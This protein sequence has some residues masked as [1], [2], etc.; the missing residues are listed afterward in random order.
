MLQDVIA[1][2][3]SRFAALACLAAI[4]A[5]YTLAAALVSWLTSLAPTARP[6]SETFPDLW[7]AAMIWAALTGG[8]AVA[9]D[10]WPASRVG[11]RRAVLLYG[12]ILLGASWVVNAHFMLPHWIAGTVSLAELPRRIHTSSLAHLPFNTVAAAALVAT[13]HWIGALQRTPGASA[14]RVRPAAA[15]SELVVIAGR[16][17]FTV[18]VAAIE[19]I[20]SADD[21]TVL[22]CG[23]AS[24]ICNERLYRLEAKLANSG[25]LRVHRSALVNVT[26]I[27]ALA[28]GNSGEL[29]VEL[30]S[31][32]R[33]RAS[34]RR[35]R[36][37]RQAI[38]VRD[39]HA[40]E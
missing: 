16:R 22:H 39:K 9:V 20:E 24:H 33:V 15:Q 38:L 7:W 10:T 25:F 5:G 23:T 26:H 34:R 18:P 32:S 19:W 29:C 30:A 31:G 4:A 8:I 14:R 11:Y 17:T 3:R 36:Q 28:A 13:F 35:R 40:P 37:V 27:S 1:F 2:R 6:F 12:A 21:Y